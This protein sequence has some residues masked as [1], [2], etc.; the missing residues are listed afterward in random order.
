MQLLWYF[1]VPIYPYDISYLDQF[2]NNENCLSLITLTLH[3]IP[4]GFIP[5]TIIYMFPSVFNDFS[6]IYEM[7][8]LSVEYIYKIQE[9][10]E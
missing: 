1:N 2:E 10:I 5:F 7:N 9:F 4:N 3:Y 6:V 8:E